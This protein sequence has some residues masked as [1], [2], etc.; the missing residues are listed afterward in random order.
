MAIFLTKPWVNPF[1]K[2]SIF[3]L[4]ELLFLSLER[5]FFVLKYR[6][7]HLPCLYCLKKIK[8]EK[9][10][11]F[12]KN[13]GLTALEKSQFFDF[14]NFFFLSLEKHFLVLQYRKRHFPVL[15]CLKKELAKMAIFFNKTM[16]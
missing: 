13:H 7:R 3:R 12:E 5:R 11:F 14:F 9:W 16:G 4:F 6:K 1:G 2:I 8:L 15:Y 10:P